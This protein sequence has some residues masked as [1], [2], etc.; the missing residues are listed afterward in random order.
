MLLNLSTLELHRGRADAAKGLAEQVLR[1]QTQAIGPRH[2]EVA[3]ALTTLGQAEFVAKDYVNAAGHF[4]QAI[5]I[6]QTMLGDTHP[7]LVEPLGGLA[8]TL[9]AQQNSAKAAE[10]YRRAIAIRRAQFGADDP[11]ATDLA[12]RLAKL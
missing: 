11:V 4:T 5:D 7:A 8:G 6:L 9:A 1:M 10:T 3:S 12:A 2:P